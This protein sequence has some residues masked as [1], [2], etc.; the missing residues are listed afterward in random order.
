MNIYILAFGFFAL[1]A[2]SGCATKTRTYTKSFSVGEQNYVA[3]V[4]TR[5]LTKS[6]SDLYADTYFTY[7][8]AEVAERIVLY[9]DYPSWQ[10]SIISEASRQARKEAKLARNE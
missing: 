7:Y 2:A 5:E 4:E 10:N 1:L 9:C 6:A 8:E 3:S